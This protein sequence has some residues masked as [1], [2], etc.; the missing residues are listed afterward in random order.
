MN[1][2]LTG[3][4]GTPGESIAKVLLRAGHAVTHSDKMHA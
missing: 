2:F 1:V 4:T 3:T